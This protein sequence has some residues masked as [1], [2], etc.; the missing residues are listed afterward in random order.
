MSNKKNIIDKKVKKVLDSYLAS[1]FL[2]CY[3]D[4]CDSMHTVENCEHTFN[5]LMDDKITIAK[6]IEKNYL[7]E[8]I[9]AW[10]EFYDET[11]KDDKD[12]YP[13][14]DVKDPSCGALPISFDKI[15]KFVTL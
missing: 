3:C 1:I 9:K 13:L 11:L 4:C 14:E 2:V 7:K 10:Q 8:Y 12:Q 5:V 15:E 6:F